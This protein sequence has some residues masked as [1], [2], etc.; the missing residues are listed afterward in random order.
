[1]GFSYAEWAGVFYPPGLKAGDRLRFYSSH[2]DTVEL[3]TTFHAMPDA[4]R[5]ARWRD[6]VPADF[7]LAVKA[8]RLVTHDAPPGSPSSLAAMR[9]FTDVCRGF[10]EKLAVLLLQ[11]P[12]TF[13]V[14]GRDGVRRLL[15]A[16]PKDLR[17]AVEFRHADWRRD[18]TAQ[19][20]R[21]H[22][23]ALVAGEYVAWP[24]PPVR[25]A[26]FLYIRWIGE[27][28]RFRDLSRE[29]ID[30]TDRLIWWKRQ[31]DVQAADVGTVFGYF[32]NDYAGY[33][34]ATCRRFQQL[35]GIPLPALPPPAPAEPTLFG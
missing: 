28:E 31:I 20:V 5:V 35:A 17:L 18:D 24:E 4:A 22:G 8:P 21:Q 23:V 33:S 9:Q 7:R 26:D 25:T 27:H 13:G 34:V 30:P 14:A 16:R 10:D 12:P 6:A 32:N 3:D 19:L 15:D 1:M 11:F 2:F 29:Q